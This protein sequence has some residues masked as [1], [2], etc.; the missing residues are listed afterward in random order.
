M[1]S[2]MCIRDRYDTDG[3]GTIDKMEREG[4]DREYD[5]EVAREG[6]EDDD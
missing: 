6:E 1:G 3:D 4:A 2:E 5:R